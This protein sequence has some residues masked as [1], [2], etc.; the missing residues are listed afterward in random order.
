MLVPLES[1]GLIRVY[2]LNGV[3]K[4]LFLLGNVV[5]VRDSLPGPSV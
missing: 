5:S 2:R 3:Q 1:S 4:S